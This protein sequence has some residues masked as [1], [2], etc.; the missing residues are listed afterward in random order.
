M[1][2]ELR[3]IYRIAN[4][5]S[6]SRPELALWMLWSADKQGNPQGIWSHETAL[7]IHELSDVSP[8]KLHMTVPK[9]FKKRNGIPKN[10]CLHFVNELPKSDVEIRQG[11]RVTTPLRS[12]ADVIREKTIQPEQIESAL[13][14]LAIQKSLIKGLATLQ[15]M[16]KLPQVTDSEELQAVIC[17]A[18][19]KVWI[20]PNNQ[21]KD[22]KQ[23]VEPYTV[24]LSLENQGFGTA[25]LC[26]YKSKCFLL[27]A[28]HVAQALRKA[29]SVTLLLRFDIIRREYKPEP[30]ENFR[31]IEWDSSFDNAA[32]N[33]VLANRPKDLA[34]V[35]PD[36]R[37][38]ENLKFYKE[39]YNI[40]DEPPSFSLKDALI[41]L[42]GIEPIYS[43]NRKTCELNMGPFGF[44]ASEYRQMADE[45]YIVCPVQTHIYEMRNLRRKTIDSFQGLSGTGL[46]KFT[47]NKPTLIGIAIA[48]DAPP[49]DSTQFR[50]IYFHGPHSILSMVREIYD[51][52]H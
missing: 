39:F 16:E 45:D 52:K 46:W 32:L 22:Y 35:I 47:N 19:D 51:N 34:I 17:Q 37:I 1:K 44:I 36:P 7:D 5:P 14:D 20:Q 21:L 24:G 2:E 29:K 25:V 41:S 12:L 15:E 8:T 4:F 27:T 48:Q 9:S 6:T 28:A 31:V 33:D 49:S 23:I 18:I 11:Y 42:G 50:N 30:A 10:L 40:L 38:V 13:L 43:E 3:G 26:Q